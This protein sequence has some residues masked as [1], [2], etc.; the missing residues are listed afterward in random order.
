MGCE[1]HL[2]Y[3]YAPLARGK[4]KDRTTYKAEVDALMTEIGS[5]DAAQADFMRRKKA[6]DD[7]KVL[8]ESE[9]RKATSFAKVLALSQTVSRK[10]T[11]SECLF[12][13]HAAFVKEFNRE[14]EQSELGEEQDLKNP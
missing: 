2:Q 11:E 3:V 7:E 5:N 9:G 4:S 6:H 1:G 10:Q 13:S 12:W 8:A 14:P